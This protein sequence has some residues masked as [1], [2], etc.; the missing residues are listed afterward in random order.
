MLV[1]ILCLKNKFG[2][3][4]RLIKKM[5]VFVIN[6]NKLNM[7]RKILGEKMRGYLVKNRI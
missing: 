3:I 6:K 5:I 1:F 4:V 2:K 7:K